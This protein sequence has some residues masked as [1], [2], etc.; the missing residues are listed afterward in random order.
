[1][2]LLGLL[3][4]LV[5]FSCTATMPSG[6]GLITTPRPPL[7]VLARPEPSSVPVMSQ[8]STARTVPEAIQE[9][10]Q[11]PEP[12]RFHRG[13]LVYTVQPG[14][15]YLVPVAVDRLTTVRFAPGEVL[16]ATTSGIPKCDDL[17]SDDPEMSLRCLSIKE[18][19]SGEGTTQQYHLALRPGVDGLQTNLMVT[20]SWWAYDLE[21]VSR[22][23]GFVPV[24]QWEHLAPVVPQAKAIRHE[25]IGHGYSMT[26]R[27]GSD[28]AWMPE[29]M[30]DDTK[31]TYIQ[32][33][34]T[35]SGGEFPLLYELTSALEE[36]LVNYRVYGTLLI[37]DGVIDGGLLQTG[38]KPTAAIV[39][40]RRTSHY[41]YMICPGHD[42][43]PP[44]T[45][46]PA[47]A[48]TP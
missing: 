8:R 20:T 10:M 42:G 4:S 11:V 30:W 18:T 29:R 37:A 13:V 16:F 46:T 6:P 34:K 25:I 5:L 44:E 9:A 40:I 39:D 43:C 24:V 14:A 3:S 1:M 21:V 33:P 15:R 31:H 2:R 27:S 12:W 23:R 7:P 45:N 36:H 17:K 47:F 22:K 48:L 38:K 32:F 35:V 28:P 41:H 19:S 26:S